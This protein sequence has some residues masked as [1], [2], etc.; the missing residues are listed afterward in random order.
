MARGLGHVGV[1]LQRAAIVFGRLRAVG[2]D[3][4]SGQPAIDPEHAF[5]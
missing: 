3:A 1:A 5:T 4:A 2:V